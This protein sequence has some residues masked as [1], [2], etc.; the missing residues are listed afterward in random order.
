M[1][2]NEFVSQFKPN[3]NHLISYGVIIL[4]LISYII[5]RATKVDITNDEA[6][7]FYN[8]TTF[9]IVEVFCT[10]N[11]HWLIFSF[12]KLLNLIGFE[13]VF[14]LRLMSVLAGIGLY[15]LLYKYYISKYT[16]LIVF[17]AF[18]L[19]G[20]N[21]YL[22]DY[23]G[24]ARGYAS[25]LLF[26]FFALICLNQ[27]I[28]SESKKWIY[29]FFISSTL[30]VIS[31]FNFFYFF[32]AS[33]AAYL[34]FSINRH[35]FTFF[36]SKDFIWW[37]GLSITCSLVTIKALQIITVC[38]ND[39]GNYGGNDFIKSIFGSQFLG[40]YN[41]HELKNSMV[42]TLGSYALFLTILTLAIISFFHKNKRRVTNYLHLLSITIFIMLALSLFNYY[43]L[44]VLYP[45][46]RT[47]MIYYF[48]FCLLIIH[49]YASFHIKFYL[50]KIIGITF[51]VLGVV[52]FLMSMN[53]SK[54]IDFPEQQNS[55]HCF[56]ILETIHAHKVGLTKELFGVYRNYYQKTSYYKYHFEGY[57]INAN[58]YFDSRFNKL[59]LN[60][61]DYIVLIP[62][63]KI[64][65]CVNTKTKL[66]TVKYF[67]KSGL[68]IFKVN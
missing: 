63:Y 51:I 65:H 39:I 27:I 33:M 54:T 29:L 57:T 60:E 12:I 43:V 49:Y 53:F 35:G 1:R 68:I 34:I 28:Y 3:K 58:E 6:Y 41:Y 9:W 48:P 61:F 31:N 7:T 4:A 2:N 30:S 17:V 21:P 25:A 22:I 64:T 66:S 20:L 11:T 32:S 40:L 52:N 36:K 13:H 18:C 67:K 44:D 45:I 24:L 59:C 37:L 46:D 19:L 38:S 55:K 23:F 16:P 14:A 15:I 8:V 50:K 26:Q 5:L 62:P 56:Q 10:G 42:I 47:A